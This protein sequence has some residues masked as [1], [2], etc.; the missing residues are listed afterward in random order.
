MIEVFRGLLWRQIGDHRKGGYRVRRSLR[1]WLASIIW[2]WRLKQ[3][4]KIADMGSQ[5]A[6]ISALHSALRENHPKYL[7]DWRQ[8]M[9]DVGCAVDDLE[10]LMQWLREDGL[11]PQSD[12]LRTIMARLANAVPEHQI[13]WSDEGKAYLIRDIARTYK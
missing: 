2:R 10:G 3:S 4:L 1:R 11:Y 6:V 5:P 13:R 8:M 12:R 7:A 9:H